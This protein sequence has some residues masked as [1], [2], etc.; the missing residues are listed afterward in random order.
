MAN[1]TLNNNKLEKYFDILKGLDNI[2]KKKLII[3][4]TESLEIEEEKVDLRS[5]FGAWEDD[6]DS[7]EIIKEIRESRIERTENP[8]FE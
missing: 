7:D 5:I 4:L 1:V 2:S 6:K 8:G 3:K